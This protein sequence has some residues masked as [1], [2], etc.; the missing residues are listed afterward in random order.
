MNDMN[1]PIRKVKAW[2]VL[3]PEKEL[4]MWGDRQILIFDTK[5][6][7][8]IVRRCAYGKGGKTVPCT[9]TYSLPT[10]KKGKKP[11]SD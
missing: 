3:S 7:A 11:L 9:I 6:Y 2:A 5:K 1:S 10:K 8:E 4:P